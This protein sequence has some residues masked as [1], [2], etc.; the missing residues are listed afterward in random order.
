MS[1]L[2]ASP[3]SLPIRTWP[4]FSCTEPK[5]PLTYRTRLIHLVQSDSTLNL[6][7]TK[8]CL[9]QLTFFFVCFSSTGQH[10]ERA[11]PQSLKLSL[12]HH[13]LFSINL[14][15]CFLLFGL[16]RLFEEDDLQL[17]ESNNFHPQNI[18]DLLFMCQNCMSSSFAHLT[19]SCFSFPLHGFLYRGHCY[20]TLCCTCHD[21]NLSCWATFWHC[22]WP[23]FAHCVS[24]EG[25]VCFF[26]LCW[27][28]LW[29]K[30]KASS[31]LCPTS[32]LITC[33]WHGLTPFVTPASS[34]RHFQV[35]A[36]IS[37]AG[38]QEHN[39]ATSLLKLTLY[40]HSHLF[41]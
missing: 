2:L 10:M 32:S 7:A 18:G 29:C 6:I 1:A 8:N 25:S 21:H 26:P 16:L 15:H 9:P 40:H 20:C 33:N 36:R 13:V 4:V 34:L 19:P 31:H 35:I 17:L 12:S 27:E 24:K 5:H 30:R 3:R 39:L 11:T 23:S 37:A 28:W 14:S 22:K 41:K 38:S